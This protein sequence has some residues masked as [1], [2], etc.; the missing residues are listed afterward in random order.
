MRQLVVILACLGMAIS[1]SGQQYDRYIDDP[2]A[3]QREQV[4]DFTDLR[5][6]VSFDPGKRLVF[7]T[8]THTFT[9]L[10]ERLDT[11]RIDGPGITIRSISWHGQPLPWEKS[12]D[13]FVLKFT[14]GPKRGAFDS[15][16][17]EYEAHPLKGIYFVG[18]DDPTNRS[19]KQIWTQGEGEDNR[20]WI[21]MFDDPADKVMQDVTITFD[22]AYQV[23]CN[24]TLVSKKDAGSQRIWQY[25]MLHPHAPYLLMLGI[26][27]YRIW[28]QKSASGV[29]LRG[30]Y[31]PDWP[32]SAE[33]TYRYTPQIMD[34]LE[35]E[36]GY[37]YPWEQ[38]S[39]IPVQD[40]MYG[41]MENT[42]AT[43]FGDFF[44]GDARMFMDTRYVG[45]NA[46]EMTH[47]WFGDLITCRGW[48]HIWLQE[49]FATHYPK[50][51]TRFFY[52]ENEYR[53][54]KRGEQ[55]TAL[56]ASK[57]DMLPIV[58]TGSGTARVYPKGS[59][60]LDMIRYLVGDETF[61]HVVS[62]YLKEHAY[63][64]VDTH[65]FIEAFQ[66]YAGYNLNWFFDQWVYRG[67]EPHY[68]VSWQS[69]IDPQGGKEV[70]VTVRQIQSKSE[71]VNLF[72]MPIVVEVYFSDGTRTAVKPWISKETEII[73]VPNISGREVAF[74]L[75]DPNNEILRNLSFE[76]TFAELKLQCQM[77]ANMLDRYDALY[78]MRS[79]PLNQKLDL[80]ID[81]W[82]KETFY[83]IRAEIIY[84]LRES[85]DN[86]ALAILAEALKDTHVNVRNAFFQHVSGIP[87][88]L[89]AP[90]IAALQDSAW[91]VSENAFIRLCETYPSERSTWLKKTNGWEGQYKS[92]R[93]K[94]IEQSVLNGDKKQLNELV[95]YASVSFEFRVRQNAFRSLKRLNY[96]D[97]RV[98]EHLLRGIAQFNGRLGSVASDVLDY[99]W[100]QSQY[101]SI[102]KSVANSITV[103]DLWAAGI[104]KYK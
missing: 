68:Q 28:E 57:R 50:H 66:K 25:R 13:G 56:D 99:F 7:G 10:R 32:W 5:L 22:S 58:N 64:V 35:K 45:V 52:G 63:D 24:G 33:P 21:P 2:T 27:K 26:G 16:R 73:H 1:L 18:W 19:R 42:T 23:L 39:Q 62:S 89:K 29:P 81:R 74:V 40:F 55:N 87:F 38:Y 82:Q 71:T 70:A 3:G 49:S 98:A 95:D 101:R 94:W 31:Y 34:F 30:W 51:F 97:E 75:F 61:R 86:R 104:Q 85:I 83:G 93:I 14:N 77:A 69:A 15:I 9:V 103:P 47:Q 90:I 36:I 88:G 78:A 46:H 79:I 37:S 54:G 41:A 84:Q 53:W 8:V 96:C 80:L 43:I 76:K 102:I 92:F 60:V 91:S 72:T 48:E 4:V 67:G 20:Y 12:D 44:C 65:D 59:F 11:L 17:I 6:N 100:Q